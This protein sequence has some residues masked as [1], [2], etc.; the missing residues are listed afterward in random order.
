MNTDN[1]YTHTRGKHHQTSPET[2]KMTPKK[3]PITTKKEPHDHARATA[4]WRGGIV[5]ANF[6]KKDSLLFI[7]QK[8]SSPT[9]QKFFAHTPARWRGGN[10]CR[11]TLWSLQA[12][13]RRAR[14]SWLLPDVADVLQCAREASACSVISVSLSLSL[15][16]SP[17]L[18]PLPDDALHTC[19]AHIL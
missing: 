7:V 1:P 5:A 3:N 12:R 19:E 16:V 13:R 9:H 15:P 14:A 10:R 17:F 2:A 4:R 8:H 11:S 6:S 18:S